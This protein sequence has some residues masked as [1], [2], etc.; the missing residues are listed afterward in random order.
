[1]K[2]VGCKEERERQD[3]EGDDASQHGAHLAAPILGLMIGIEDFG[4][5]TPFPSGR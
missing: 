5:R 1:V 2:V 3:H 4:Q